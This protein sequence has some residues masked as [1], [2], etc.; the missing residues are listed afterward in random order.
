MRYCKCSKNAAYEIHCTDILSR[1]KLSKITSQISL[2]R[3]FFFNIAL[4]NLN[5]M[6]YF[7]IRF[8]FLSMYSLYVGEC[9][10]VNSTRI[11]N[12]SQNKSSNSEMY[13]FIILFLG[14]IPHRIESCNLGS[15]NIQKSH[16]ECKHSMHLRMDNAASSSRVGSMLRLAFLL[17][18]VLPSG[19][20]NKIQ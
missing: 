20:M 2:R 3:N 14:G 10:E 16:M 1:N 7:V 8:E 11:K 6:I 18:F 4:P 9:I 12:D 13:H 17:V 15:G 5:L 19:G